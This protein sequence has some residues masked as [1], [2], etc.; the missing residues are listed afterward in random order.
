MS[1]VEANFSGE[2]V[3]FGRE[4]LVRSKVYL[5]NAAPLQVVGLWG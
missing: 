5:P 1:V 4:F 2:G 3:A